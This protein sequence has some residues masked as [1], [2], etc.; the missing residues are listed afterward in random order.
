[1]NRS[2]RF[3]TDSDSEILPGVGST[4]PRPF[5]GQAETTPPGY[6]TDPNVV[7]PKSTWPRTLTL[8]ERHFLAAL[9]DII[10]PANGNE[11]APSELGIEDFFDDW[12]SAPYAGNVADRIQ[13]LTGLDTVNEL[14]TKLF[15][16]DFL[17]L[18][19]T[20]KRKTLDQLISNG[21][22]G[23]GFFVRLR[24]LVVGAY[25]T[26]DAGMRIIG[27]LG[28]VPLQKPARISTEARRIVKREL[29]KLG[30]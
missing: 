6:G 14:A 20:R 1:M 21:G 9:S 28:N 18:P 26:S 15:K 4:L 10:L 16:R 24:Y 19:D 3:P 13:I 2:H 8:Y 22:T 29:R 25:F 27:Y 17:E 11:P 30:L 5:K 12:L 7:T 23:Q